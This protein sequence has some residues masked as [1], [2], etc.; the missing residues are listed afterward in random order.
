MKIEISS[1]KDIIGKLKQE[2]LSG[3]F[4]NLEYGR[5]IEEKDFDWD[6]EQLSLKD[7]QYNSLL[8]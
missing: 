3:V 1:L 8:E 7:E 6:R 2:K 4:Q 5:L